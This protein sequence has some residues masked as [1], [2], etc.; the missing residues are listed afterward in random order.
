VT[1]GYR[2]SPAHKVANRPEFIALAVRY[3]EDSLACVDVAAMPA[4]VQPH[5]VAPQVQGAQPLAPHGHRVIK[6]PEHTPKTYSQIEY[7][8]LEAKI[9]KFLNSRGQQLVSEEDGEEID[10]EEDEGRE[11]AE[12]IREEY[13]GEDMAGY[14]DDMFAE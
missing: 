8:G 2:E 10:G 7:D 13:F 12:E 6:L 4:P 11:E 3:L 5:P 14:F 9:R 1:G